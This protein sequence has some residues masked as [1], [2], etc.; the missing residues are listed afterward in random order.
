MSDDFQSFQARMAAEA[1]QHKFRSA[2]PPLQ[3]Y[4]DDFGS[5]WKGPLQPNENLHYARFHGI[6]NA[7]GSEIW[8]LERS[9]AHPRWE[10]MPDRM[11]WEALG[12][13]L[14]EWANRP[15]RADELP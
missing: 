2:K 6:C 15:R 11:A 4:C 9:D 14:T 12:R 13:F 1:E 8:I 5:I 3:Y 10:P 7:D